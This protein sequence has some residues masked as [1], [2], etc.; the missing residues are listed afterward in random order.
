MIDTIK[1]RQALDPNSTPRR[2]SRKTNS[3]ATPQLNTSTLSTKSTASSG[4]TASLIK[5][6][7]HGLNLDSSDEGSVYYNLSNKLPGSIY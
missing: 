4:T 5:K 1:K 6:V 7:A 2:C 3:S